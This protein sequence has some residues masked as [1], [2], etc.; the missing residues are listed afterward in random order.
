MGHGATQIRRDR[1]LGMGRLR[2]E[3][4]RRYVHLRRF[5]VH[6][7]LHADDPPHK[8][9]LGIAI[10][11]F[12]AFTP[13][14]GFQT[15]LALFFAWLLRANKVVGVPIVWISNPATIVPIYYPCY[16]LG[17]WILDQPG[18][19]KLWW[20]ELAYPPQGWWEGIQFY[21]GRTLEIWMPLWL[22]CM[23]VATLVGVTSYFVTRGMIVAYRHGREKV[24]ET[25]RAKQRRRRSRAESA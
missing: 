25:L 15:V 4:L 22:G 9:A 12:F 19:G 24:A 11:V 8:L 1:G 10:A 6:G 2:T 13:T 18:K 20:K 7:V 14:I 16:R 5:M 23:I 3:L 21:W 17:L